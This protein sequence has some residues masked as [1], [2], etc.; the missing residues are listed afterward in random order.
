M[1]IGGIAAVLSMFFLL[2]QTGAIRAAENSADCTTIYLISQRLFIGR[3]NQSMVEI[4]QSIDGSP[5]RVQGK[6][7]RGDWGAFSACGKMLRLKIRYIDN[8]LRLSGPDIKIESNSPSFSIENRG[9]VYIR[10]GVRE[11]ELKASKGKDVIAD[12]E[13]DLGSFA[14]TGWDWID[15]REEYYGKHTICAF[16]KSERCP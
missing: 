5:F 4:S 1:S 6:L 8:G 16:E 7:F 14:P 9:T 13:H 15:R 2:G 3:Y 12:I 11:G 10:V